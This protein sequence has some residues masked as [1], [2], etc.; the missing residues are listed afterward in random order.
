MF[1][2]TTH[3][4]S[5]L[6]W[7]FAGKTCLPPTLCWAGYAL[8]VFTPKQISER[9]KPLFHVCVN[10]PECP[11]IGEKVQFGQDEQSK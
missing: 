11:K 4:V 9:E 6:L 2:L 7:H 5:C 3:T 8:N 10:E 1:K